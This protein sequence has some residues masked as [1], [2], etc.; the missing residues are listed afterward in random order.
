MI[1]YRFG[2]RTV[3]VV[4]D[5]ERDAALRTRA[6]ARRSLVAKDN[7]KSTQPYSSVAVETLKVS[8][9]LPVSTCS[10]PVEAFPLEGILVDAFRSLI[11]AEHRPLGVGKL[12]RH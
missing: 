5:S 11:A 10:P 2:S 12:W 3:G 4:F 6:L 8:D 9:V 1:D 7:A